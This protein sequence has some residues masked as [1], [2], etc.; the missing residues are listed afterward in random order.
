MCRRNRVGLAQNGILR[1]PGGDH[2]RPK[3][4]LEYDE[5]LIRSIWGKWW[6]A[7]SAGNLNIKCFNL[8]SLIIEGYITSIEFLG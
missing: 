2:R 6:P 1:Q 5:N 4:V 7:F 3:G 8:E